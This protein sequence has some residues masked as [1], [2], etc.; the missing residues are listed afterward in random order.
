MLIKAVKAADK[1]RMKAYTGDMLSRQRG[2]GSRASPGLPRD[3]TLEEA[4]GGAGEG[5]GGGVR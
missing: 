5:G 4:E 1:P 2:S 3:I